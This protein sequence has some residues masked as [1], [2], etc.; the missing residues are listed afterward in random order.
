MLYF[1]LIQCNYCRKQTG[2]CCTLSLP[3]FKWLKHN[4]FRNH[5]PITHALLPGQWTLSCVWPSVGHMALNAISISSAETH[6]SR[7]YKSTWR[8][9]HTQRH[10]QKHKDSLGG[11]NCLSFSPAQLRL[12][13]SPERERRNR[14][15]H[16][17]ADCCWE[18][19]LWRRPVVR[20]AFRE[21]E[22]LCLKFWISVESLSLLCM[23]ADSFIL[24]CFSNISGRRSQRNM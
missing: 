6:D 20:K 9:T 16:A 22:V 11:D 12:P 5:C 3:T 4:L 2:W 7:F 24:Q 18:A 19:G 23:A 10:I 14:G 15:R 13:R 1:P 8:C 21:G 17:G